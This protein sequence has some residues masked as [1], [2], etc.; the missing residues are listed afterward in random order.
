MLAPTGH[1]FLQELTPTFKWVNFILGAVSS[2]SLGDDKS[3]ISEPYLSQEQWKSLLRE[4]GFDNIAAVYNDQQ[5]STSIIARTASPKVNRRI[6]LLSPAGSSQSYVQEVVEVLEKKG[7]TIDLRAWGEETIPGQDILSLMDIETPFMKEFPV[8]KYTEMQAFVRG[9]KGSGVL[10]VTGLAQINCV[11][12]SYG[13]MIGLSR[14]MR[15]EQTVDFATI[16]LES[17]DAAGWDA[18]AAVLPEFQ[19]RLAPDDDTNAIMEWAVADGYINISRFHW[20]SLNEELAVSEEGAFVRRL[21]VEKRGFLNTL[22]WKEHTPEKPEGDNLR[23]RT[24]TSGLNFKD[25]LIA[26]GIVDGIVNEGDGLGLE[27]A[28]VVEEIGPDVKDLAVGDRCIAF[29]SG[30]LSSHLTTTEYLCVKIPDGLSF[31]EAATMPTVYCTAIYSLADKAGVEPGQSVLI[32][33]AAGGV[34]IA[35]IQV[36]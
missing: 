35:A 6:T 21:D 19:G 7:Y 18:I 33:S 31:E 27:A 20:T 22:Y 34:G 11:D 17:F 36:W 29:A 16:E 5:L 9:L 10:W 26:M 1:L 13:L 30:A 8:E 32:H 4:A 23:I 24:R 15:T 12:P 28:G 3:W 25:V 14:T 2:W